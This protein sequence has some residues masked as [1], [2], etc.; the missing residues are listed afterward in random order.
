MSSSNFNVNSKGQ[1]L[2]VNQANI[3]V[4]KEKEKQEENI[5]L[6]ATIFPFEIKIIFLFPVGT[7]I[8]EV[9]N[10]IQETVRGMNVGSFSIGKVTNSEHYIV[11]PTNVSIFSL[12]LRKLNKFL[13]T[14]IQYLYILKNIK[15]MKEV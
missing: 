3:R 13:M 15:S 5:K 12:F 4:V 1:N 7:Y 2:N 8:S 11:L 10:Y 14:T 6:Y 9:K